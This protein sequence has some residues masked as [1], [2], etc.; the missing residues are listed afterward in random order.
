MEKDQVLVPEI[1]AKPAPGPQR[2]QMQGP[3][4]GMKM[5]QAAPQQNTIGIE[6][7]VEDSGATD[8]RPRTLFDAAWPITWTNVPTVLEDVAKQLKSWGIVGPKAVVLRFDAR[9]TNREMVAMLMDYIV[10]NVRNA[11]LEAVIEVPS[12]NASADRLPESVAGI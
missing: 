1:I 2:M 9:S 7:F 12:K 10:L 6:L 5:P 11:G 4:H 3:P 8:L